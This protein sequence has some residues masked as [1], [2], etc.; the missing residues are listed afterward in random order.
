MW[1]EYASGEKCKE[2]AIAAGVQAQVSNAISG[3]VKYI[4]STE[5]NGKRRGV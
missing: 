3:L 1:D 2:D 4:L 5:H